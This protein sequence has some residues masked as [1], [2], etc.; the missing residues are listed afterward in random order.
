MRLG[1]R[2]CRSGGTTFRTRTAH[3]QPTHRAS[4][5]FTPA[6]YPAGK[7]AGARVIEEK[8]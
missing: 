4:N 3:L 6:G 2:Y 5:A 8:S 1:D 7:D